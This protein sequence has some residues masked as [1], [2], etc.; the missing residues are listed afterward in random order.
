MGKKKHRK[1]YISKGQRNNVSRENLSIAREPAS[2]LNKIAA[3]R[4]GKKGYV[5]IANPNRQETNRRSIKVT[6]EQ[7]FGG[8]YKN[9][10]M[11]VKPAAEN[12]KA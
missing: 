12:D 11:R 4:A 5:T 2:I 6:F 8:T 3:W 7:F 10:M 1:S 9:I